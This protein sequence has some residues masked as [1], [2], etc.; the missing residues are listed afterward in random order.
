MIYRNTKEML[1][2]IR[3]KDVFTPKVVEEDFE[4]MTKKQLAEYAKNRGIELD[5]KATKAEMI[6]RLK[7]EI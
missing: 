4:S 1:N 2:A 5:T 3:G 6:G 7:N